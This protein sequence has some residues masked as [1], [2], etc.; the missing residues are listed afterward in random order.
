MHWLKL[1]CDLPRTGEE[2]VAAWM[3]EAGAL[4]AEWLESAPERVEARIYFP[5]GQDAEALSEE[6]L[7]L[8]RGFGCTPALRLEAVEDERWVE[9]YQERLAPFDVGR[10]FRV[11]PSGPA[12][13]PSPP[14]GD[15]LPLV[16]S[17]GRAFG[18]GEHATTRQCLEYLEEQIRPGSAVLDVGTGS[19]I[20]AIA[21]VLLGAARVVAVE[22]DREAAAVAVRNFRS[23]GV[24]GQIDLLPETIAAVPG[25]QFDRITA[26]I[27]ARPLIELLPAIEPHLPAGG[28]AILAGIQAPDEAAVRSAA[29]RRGLEV[30]A[31][32]VESGWVAFEI[33]RP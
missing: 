29:E 33:G 10:R 1:T 15:R 16:V 13:G 23:N 11:Y 20:L 30:Q 24:A 12:G 26:N 9:T 17:P 18:T 6:F 2:T 19:G 21:A 27:L 32:R 25:G 3:E 8:C 22:P 7:A 4:G 31:R 14:G 28:G 5:A